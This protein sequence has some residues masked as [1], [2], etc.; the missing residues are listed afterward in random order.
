MGELPR[1]RVRGASFL[2]PS[3]SARAATSPQGRGLL[4]GRSDSGSLREG[5]PDEVG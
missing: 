2:I 3:P 4:M 5:A 1:K